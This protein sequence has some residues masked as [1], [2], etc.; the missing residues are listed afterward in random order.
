MGD[1]K[2]FGKLIRNIGG[3]VTVQ[4][5][6]AAPIDVEHYYP[7]LFNEINDL[8]GIMLATFVEDNIG[9]TIEGRTEAVERDPIEAANRIV[10]TVRNCVRMKLN[11]E[12]L[13]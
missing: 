8:R 2:T 9:L 11:G 10:K 1:F 13:V 5:Q 7:M 6:D 12:A 3:K 4:I